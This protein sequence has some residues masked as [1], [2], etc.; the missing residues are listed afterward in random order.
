[1]SSYAE[2][3]IEL[4]TLYFSACKAN[5]DTPNLTAFKASME[6]VPL[7]NRPYYI[8]FL[9]DMIQEIDHTCCKHPNPSDFKDDKQKCPDCKYV[10]YRHFIQDAVGEEYG[11]GHY[12]YG[13]WK[14]A[15][16]HTIC[17]SLM[18]V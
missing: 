14:E 10:R 13:R 8:S 7:Y 2:H 16:V 4:A 6:E 3:L 5:P 12:E 9:N 18:G 1:M 15:P 17:N 11:G